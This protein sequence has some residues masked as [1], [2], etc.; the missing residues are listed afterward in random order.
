MDDHNRIWIGFG[1]GEWGG[2]LFVF[3][4]GKRRFLRPKLYDYRITLNPVRSFAQSDK[5]VFMTAGMAHFTTHGSIVAFDDLSARVVLSSES[6]WVPDTTAQG[7]FK[8]GKF[9]KGGEYIG[10]AAY[11]SQENTCIFTRKMA[12]LKETLIMT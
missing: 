11:N 12:F 10:L 5:N 2:N 1:Y 3:D 7:P 4:T 6:A 9:L 8:G